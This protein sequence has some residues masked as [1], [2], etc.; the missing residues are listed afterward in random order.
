[1]FMSDLD[2]FPVLFRKDLLATDA[3]HHPY[4]E[5]LGT[6]VKKSI[7]N[8]NYLQYVICLIQ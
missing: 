8:L 1:M 3:H 4:I 7:Y 6:M 2:K 5:L